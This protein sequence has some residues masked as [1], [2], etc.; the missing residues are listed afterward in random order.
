MARLSAASRVG[1][2]GEIIAVLTD[3]IQKNPESLDQLNYRFIFGQLREAKKKL[4][5]GAGLPL[6]Q[7]L[8]AA[9]WKVEWNQEPSGIWQD[10][11][12][13]LLEQNRL[14][15]ATEVSTHVTDEYAL[16][17]MRADK[18]FDPITTANPG[19][20]DVDAALK[21]HIEHFQSVAENTPKAL[22]PRAAVVEFLMEQGRYGGALAAADGVVAEIR[23]RSDAKQWYSDFDSGYAWV[24]D[25]R[26]RALRRVGR[27]DEGVDQLAAASWVSGTDGKNVNQV[28][29]LVELYCDMGMPK[30]ALQAL[31]RLGTSMS[32]YGRMQE[33]AVRLDAAIQL[34]D[35]DETAKWL[36]FEK[37]HRSNAPR[38][39]EDAL[40][41]MN[42]VETAAEWLIERL[43]D[44]DQRSAALLAVQEY[45]APNETQRQSELRKRWR[46]LIARPDVQAAAQKVG[47]I[48][49]Y[50]IEQLGQ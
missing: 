5:H 21:R 41:R 20:F 9:H 12:L 44:R 7:A 31:V 15:E 8:Y 24:L 13:S 10:L 45:A 4:L 29:N 16:I 26:S 33:A 42:D 22:M 18:R 1:D 28:I 35:A 11:T 43:A 39:Y 17:S 37:E 27:W 32:D 14:S 3:M 38:T 47:R 34:G 23:Q 49:S 46:A 19:Q 36:G 40:L 6:M 2:T 30:E 48:E 50:R 25:T